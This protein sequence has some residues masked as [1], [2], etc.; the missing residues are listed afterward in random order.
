MRE[1]LA[2]LIGRNDFDS[3]ECKKNFVV[4]KYGDCSQDYDYKTLN[5]FYKEI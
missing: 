3:F 1:L 4:I 5:R 2:L